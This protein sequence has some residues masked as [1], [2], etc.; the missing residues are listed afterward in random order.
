MLVAVAE[1][2]IVEVYNLLLEIG[3][4]L[5][6]VGNQLVEVGSLA[7]ADSLLV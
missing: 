6:K 2:V 1:G 4:L 7:E 5:A 3:C